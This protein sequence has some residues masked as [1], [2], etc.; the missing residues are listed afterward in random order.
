[1]IDQT[2]SEL[3][4]RLADLSAQYPDV[5]LG[6]LI[7]NLATLAKGPQVEGIWDAEDQELLKAAKQQLAVLQSRDPAVA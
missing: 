3:L 1:M 2:R 7:C 6:Q 4:E 5:R